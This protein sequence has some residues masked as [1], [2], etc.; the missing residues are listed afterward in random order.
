MVFE[1]GHLA[2]SQIRLPVTSTV[3][4]SSLSL[5]TSRPSRMRSLVPKISVRAVAIT[6]RFVAFSK[7]LVSWRPMPREEGDVKIHG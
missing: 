5:S 4:T 1:L 3:R 2:V 6:G 7:R